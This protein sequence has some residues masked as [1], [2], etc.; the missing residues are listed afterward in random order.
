M[1]TIKNDFHDTE[2]RT[3]KTAEEINKIRNTPPDARTD[4]ERAW[5]NKVR[6]TL[7]GII[8]CTCGGEFGERK[9]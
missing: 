6:R 3:K 2:F 8:G 5:V 7:C 9:L 4:A 1:I